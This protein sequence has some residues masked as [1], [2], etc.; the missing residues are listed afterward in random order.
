MLSQPTATTSATVPRS[1]AIARTAVWG[2]VIRSVAYLG[3][4]VIGVFIAA[5]VATNLW[6][7]G[8]RGQAPGL[9]TQLWPFAV[10]LPAVFLF[11][12]LY[13]GAG[14]GPVETLRRLT[15]GTSGSFAFLGVASFLFKAGATYSR[16]T[17][18]IAWLLSLVAV[19][20]MR[21]LTSA[22]TKSARWSEPAVLIG[23]GGLADQAEQALLTSRFLGYVPTRRLEE[24]PSQQQA[25]A[26]AAEGFT[27]AIL[28][29]GNSAGLEQSFRVL[30]GYFSRIVTL[31][32]GQGLP[33][34]GIRA[35]N[36]GGVLGTEFRDDL[37]IRR[38]QLLKRLVDLAIGSLLLL[39]SAPVILLA[40]VLVKLCDRGPAFYSQVREGVGGKRFRVHKIRTMCV[41]AEK[42]LQDEFERRP[43]LRRE[44]Q[45]SFKLT[46]DPRII[47][48]VGRFLRRWSIDELPQLSSVVSGD[49]SLVGPR[50]FPEYHLQG[51]SPDF[52]RL[53]SRVRPGLTGLWQVMVRSEGSIAQQE[54]FDT[55][56]IRNWSI[57]LDLYV[58]A[59]TLLA[60]VKGRGAF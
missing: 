3:G 39:L 27:T 45:R 48:G 38:N 43:E 8:V 40:A 35:L 14:L 20:L 36:L 56:Y 26:L 12:G 55:Y 47:P 11:L 25:E 4:D 53:R 13:P 59:Q 28:A 31:R 60:V 32:G 9:Y 44:W 29:P 21:G 34:D 49:M 58:L 18:L 10:V 41:D 42:R 15:L 19:P 5:I 30:E 33:V 52:R 57:W 16:V 6:A 24:I 1:R 54:S 50:P 23:S 22:L 17:F 51:F 37:L 7:I 46:D 2:R